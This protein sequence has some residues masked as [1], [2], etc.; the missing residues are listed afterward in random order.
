MDEESRIITKAYKK[1]RQSIADNENLQEPINENAGTQTGLVN[2]NI[3]IQHAA[4]LCA[5]A[6]LKPPIN[7][8]HCMALLSHTPQLPV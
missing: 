7:S 8:M 3:S 4:T 5:R 2:Q 6:L 1:H